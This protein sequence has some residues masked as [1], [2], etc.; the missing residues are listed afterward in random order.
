MSSFKHDLR[1]ICTHRLPLNYLK[2]IVTKDNVVTLIISCL[3]VIK[4]IWQFR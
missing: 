4:E 3:T 2:V 1:S